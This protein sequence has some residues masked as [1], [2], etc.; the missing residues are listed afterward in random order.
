LG[1]RLDVVSLKLKKANG[2]A[3]ETLPVTPRIDFTDLG[4]NA[5]VPPP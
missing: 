4:Y 2:A 3:V 1:L 5:R